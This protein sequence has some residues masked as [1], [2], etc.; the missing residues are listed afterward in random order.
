M[1]FGVID[2]ELRRY[3]RDVHDHLLRVVP[4]VHGFRELLSTA[5]HANL[6]QISVRQNEDMRRI[7][8]MGR[9]PG[10]PDRGGWRST[11]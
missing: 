2:K 8:G 1:T 6:T 11:A 7:S 3:I 5:L 9:D 4:Q 10:G